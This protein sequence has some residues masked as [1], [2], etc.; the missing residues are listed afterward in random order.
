M[1]KLKCDDDD[2]HVMIDIKNYDDDEEK[3][4]VFSIE[5]NLVSKLV[6]V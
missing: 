4:I 6:S 2:D 5:K 3:S 1:L